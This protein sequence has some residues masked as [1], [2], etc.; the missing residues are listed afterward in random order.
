AALISDSEKFKAIGK[1]TEIGFFVVLENGKMIDVNKTESA[2]AQGLS[3]TVSEATPSAKRNETQASSTVTAASLISVGPLRRWPSGG[4]PPVD[5]EGGLA[6]FRDSFY[7][8]NFSVQGQVHGDEWWV[9]NLVPVSDGSTDTEVV[10]GSKLYYYESVGSGE[11]CFYSPG[12][13]YYICG[14]PQISITYRKVL[15]CESAGQWTAQFMENGVQVAPDMNFVV[16]PEVPPEDF[17]P[18]IQQTATRD[19]FTGEPVTY[20]SSCHLADNESDYVFCPWNE[21]LIPFIEPF[22]IG[23]K[24]CAMST[25]AMVAEYHGASIE[26]IWDPQSGSYYNRQGSGL[27]GMNDWLNR[28]NGFHHQTASDAHGLVIWPKTAEYGRERGANIQWRAF[29]DDN[30]EQTRNAICEYGPQGMYVSGRQHFVMVVGKNG[31][32]P[33]APWKIH[34]PATGTVTNLQDARGGAYGNSYRSTRLFSAQVPSEYPFPIYGVKIQLFSPVELLVTAPDG[35]KTGLDPLT[36]EDLNEIPNSTYTDEALGND[37][38]GVLD[39]DPVKIFYLSDGFEA[40]DYQVTV[41]GTGNG[42]YDMVISQYDKFGNERGTTAMEDTPI[43]EDEVHLYRVS[44]DPSTASQPPQVAGGFD[45]KGQR[46]RDVNKFLSYSNPSA[47]RTYVEADTATYRIAVSYGSTVQ[48]DTFAAELDGIDI[49][50]SF[51]PI[52]GESE[53]VTIPVQSGRNVLEL[54][55]DGMVDSGRIATDSDRLVIIRP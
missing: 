42:D 3:S 49:T 45:G 4:R 52:P 53:S 35:S 5:M 43:R 41:T 39:P 8:F 17:P 2:S 32:S 1:S 29:G 15:Q 40:G 20:D 26:N 23:E 31:V 9:R 38:T 16:M 37:V 7:G 24:G 51:N 33:D 34:D 55:I 14:S 11:S 48:A 10:D 28:N 36:T 46:P 6:Y 54:S 30:D 12:W 47:S 13:L 27:A 25:A 50:N 18:P 19:P 21:P 44:I 22:T